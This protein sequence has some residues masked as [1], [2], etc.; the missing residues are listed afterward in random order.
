MNSHWWQELYPSANNDDAYIGFFTIV[1]CL[2][3]IFYFIPSILVSLFDSILGNILL[4]GIAFFV[5]RV[6]N[7]KRGLA[8][9]L[10]IV[11]LIRCV[12][13]L[14]EHSEYP[15]ESF[16]L[17]SS[18]TDS[19]LAIQRTTNPMILFDVEELKQ[20]VNQTT[21]DAY[22]QNGYWDW[23]DETTQLY[24]DAVD[25]NPMIRTY[26]GDAVAYAKQI[27]NENAI[28][29][30]L[31]MQSK[32]GQFLISGVEI[33]DDDAAANAQLSSGIG[34]FGGLDAQT[35]PIIKCSSNSSS[36]SQLEKTSFTGRGDIFGEQL[37]TK[38][39]IADVDIEREIP[40]FHFLDKPCNPCKA[41][42]SN[43]DTSCPFELNIKH[44]PEGV[45]DVWTQLWNLS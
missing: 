5:A 39:I 44:T 34:T 6:Y 25:R 17:S 11:I 2:W 31:A 28:L 32:E 12:S 3:V 45:S 14:K 21:L 40:G 1:V 24:A 30:I 37:T 33:V 20:Q 35:N 9:A 19:F 22:L 23:S 42:G 36:S 27:Y 18:S 41:F 10:V 4:F 7:V 13:L 38:N 8:V 43:L 26:S 29:R 15:K 16:E